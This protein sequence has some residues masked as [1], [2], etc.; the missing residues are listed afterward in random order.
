MIKVIERKKQKMQQKAFLDKPIQQLNDVLLYNVR[1]V[2][3]EDP[4]R[5]SHPGF[6]KLPLTDGAA[7]ERTE[8][9][10]YFYYIFLFYNLHTLA[11]R[12]CCNPSLCD[13]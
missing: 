8:E 4:V 13:Y 2:G 9:R 10:K 7:R 3:E 12:T 5:L 11:L 1:S 6:L